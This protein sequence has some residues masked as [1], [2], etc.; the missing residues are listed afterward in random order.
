VLDKALGEDHKGR[1]NF[2]ELRAV[3]SI[4][5]RMQQDAT[6]A[7]FKSHDGAGLGVITTEKEHHFGPD[8][9]VTFTGSDQVPAISEKLQAGV[10]YHLEPCDPADGGYNTNKTFKLFSDCERAQT[11]LITFKAGELTS[12]I[13][14]LEHRD[15]I[16]IMDNLMNMTHLTVEQSGSMVAL[17]NVTMLEGKQKLDF[18]TISKGHSRIPVYEG[19]PHNVRGFLLV[20]RLIL[21]FGQEEQK[22]NSSRDVKDMDI[23]RLVAIPPDMKLLDLLRVFQVKKRHLAL[24]TSNPVAVEAAW[25]GNEQVP[26]DIWMMGIITLEDVIEKLVGGIEDEGDSMREGSTTRDFNVQLMRQSTTMAR[27]RQSSNADDLKT[28]LLEKK[29]SR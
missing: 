18:S 11:D 2:A 1:Y 26:V 28:P 27:S 5:T 6:Q 7:I 23:V 25:E 10:V 14:K 4:H 13:F 8:S 21:S 15:E 12:G 20:K 9:M 29:G 24:V 19:H 16:K 17:S 22:A 3:V